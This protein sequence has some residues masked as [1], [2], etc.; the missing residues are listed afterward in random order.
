MNIKKYSPWNWFQNEKGEEQNVPVR[1]D[2]A[3]NM[4]TYPISQLHRE[5]D[6]LFDDAFRGFPGML[7]RGWEW[8][9][10]ELIVLSPNLDIKETAK[11][12]VVSVEVPGVAKEDVDIQID[13]NDLTI[14]GQ[15]RQERKDD[16]ENYHCVERHYGKFERVLT[17]PQ[18][19]SIENIDAKF[20]DGIL[21]I[22]I[23]R[24][25]KAAPKEARKI[26]V[27]AA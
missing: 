17:L 19:A 25:A 8:P 21:T 13:G 26:E 24:K 22:N 1:F 2:L 3:R 10:Q 14:R 16:K 9:E 20:K 7:R 23:K 27:K 11:D 12:Y 15:K 18:D 6:H 5:I 4:S